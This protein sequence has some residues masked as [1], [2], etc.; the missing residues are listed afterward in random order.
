MNSSPET[1][2]PA[3]EGHASM[4]DLPVELDARDLALDAAHPVRSA[5]ARRYRA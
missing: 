5:K 2:R 4:A 1:F 3:F